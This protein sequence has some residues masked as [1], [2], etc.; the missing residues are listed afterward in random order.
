MGFIRDIFI[1]IDAIVYG[2][3]EQIFQL[4][5]NLANFDLFSAGVLDEFAKRIYLILGLV[6]VFKLILSFIQILIDPDKL[7]DKETGVANILKRVVISMILI[8]LVPSIF[9]FAKQLQNRVLP[10]IPKVVLGIPLD[11]DDS[12]I[13][14]NAT[15]TD[16]IA[17]LEDEQGN[18]MVS[19]GK[20]M[21]YYS[22][23]PFFYY[24]E[25]CEGLGVL[26]GTTSE[27]N[28]ANLDIYSVSDAV[29]HVNDKNCGQSSHDGYDYN[30]RYIISTLVGAY[31][32]YVLVTVALKIAIRA[33]KFGLCQLV[34]PIPIASYIDP[35]SSKKA[36][37]NWVSTS[38]K[39]YLDLFMRLI[40][41][42]FIIYVFRLLFDNEKF[43]EVL[44]KYGAF[45]GLLVALFIITGLLYFAKEM[46]KFVSD[47]L[48]VPDGFSDIG[49]MFKGQGWRA[50]GT[51]IG[52]T[53]GTA[54]ASIGAG[55]GN[56]RYSWNNGQRLRAVFRGLGG[57]TGAQ[58]RGV[59]ALATNKGWQG[60]FTDNIKTVTSKSHRHSD[61]QFIAKQSKKEYDAAVSAIKAKHLSA[62]DEKAAID[63]L[64]KPIRP[65][66]DA[67]SSFVNEWQGLSSNVET[68]QSVSSAASTLAKLRADYYTGEA[69]K[70]LAEEGYK[71]D[72]VTHDYD[73]GT[74]TGNKIKGLNYRMIEQAYNEVQNGTYTGTVNGQRVD[75]SRLKSMFLEAQKNG[76]VDYVNA[77]LGRIAGVTINNTTMQEMDKQIEGIIANLG[78]SGKLKNTLRQSYRTDPGKFF[79]SLSD[80]SK[81]LET[82]GGR[83]SAFEQQQE[84]KN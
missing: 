9:S 42:Y 73:D 50:I 29:R 48:G 69:M 68:G 11:V 27:E 10:L 63:A 53:V 15:T 13:S 72:G 47:M 33:I 78:V 66:R 58:A 8:V 31:M 37:D 61:A 83:R 3:L 34:A 19:T 60:A 79:K 76:A 40:V 36:F 14:Y 45:Q 44:G 5:I 17:K 7:S 74:G 6:M 82:S 22:F 43:F 2:I 65:R 81:Q 77:S 35:K 70:K 20:L 71:L 1:R 24:S 67:I 64:P 4:I 80:I 75:A 39:V 26:Y 49:D 21:A 46:P 25:G 84:K 55:V 51:T 30:Y 52:G 56:A 38:V 23:L 57:F 16:S 28:S 32:V 18:V 62:A 54:A 12:Q 41:V 59:K